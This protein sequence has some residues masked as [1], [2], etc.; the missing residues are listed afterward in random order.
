MD[1]AVNL[2]TVI[3]QVCREKNISRE[4]LTETVEQAVLAGKSDVVAAYHFL[5]SHE[6]I[7]PS[8]IGVVGASYSGEETAEAGRLSGYAALYVLLSPGSLSS[9]SI[10]SMGPSGV[11]WLFVTGQDD[12]F[13]QDITESVRTMAPS[14]EL[15]V[16]P[17]TSHATDLLQEHESLAER[18]AGWIVLRLSE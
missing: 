1:E 16:V 8:R 9:V 5:E 6:A 2:N 17:G 12:P 14:T 13:L 4:I 11:P 10:A 7:D 3:D 18:I 15:I